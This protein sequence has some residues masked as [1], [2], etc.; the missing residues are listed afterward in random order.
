MP[1]V[2][3]RGMPVRAIVLLTLSRLQ[4]LRRSR[5]AQAHGKSVIMIQY[6][7]RA[8]VMPRAFYA[9]VAH[10]RCRAALMKFRYAA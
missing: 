3:A 7:P 2:A 10:M 6:A 9:R 5:E 1:V 4:H 8:A